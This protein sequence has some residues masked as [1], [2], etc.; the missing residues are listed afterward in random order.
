[1]KLNQ[2]QLAILRGHGLTELPEA[3]AG[4]AELRL[5][6]ANAA[7]AANAATIAD[8][9]STE[10][11]IVLPAA[12][13]AYLRDNGLTF[14]DIPNL[15]DDQRA[16]FAFWGSLIPKPDAE[17]HPAVDEKKPEALR[18]LDPAKMARHT[19]TNRLLINDH[20]N[21]IREAHSEQGAIV[22]RVS[23]DRL[24]RAKMMVA[25]YLED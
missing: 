5:R 18:K 19:S 13:E 25:P 8:P 20:W 24:Q 23:E 14:A 2:A 3:G 10:T 4:N 16:A 17:T 11:K 9:E 1:M 7:N 21:T 12:Q 15:S 6:V 22:R